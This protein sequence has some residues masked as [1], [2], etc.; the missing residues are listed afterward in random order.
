MEPAA[1]LVRAFEVQIH[2]RRDLRPRR[3][4]A[5]ERHHPNR[6]DIHD[7]GDLVVV[8]HVGADQFARIEREPGFDAAHSDAIRDLVDDLERTRMQLT[9]DAMHEQRNRHAPGALTRDAPVGTVLDHAGDALFAPG[10]RPLHLL[11]V[12]QRASAQ[13]RA[14][15]C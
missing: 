8:V 1:M 2:R 10:W 13:A 7:V 14:G 12:A 9:A 11:D 6:P 3:A 5:L 4:D 15:P